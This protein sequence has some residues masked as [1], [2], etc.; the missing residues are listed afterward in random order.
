[1]PA[2]YPCALVDKSNGEQRSQRQTNE[3][4]LLVATAR[5]ATWGKGVSAMRA[6]T[7]AAVHAHAPLPT[8]CMRNRMDAQTA[9]QVSTNHM[10]VA[11]AI[12]A[13]TRSFHRLASMRT[14]LRTTAR[15]K[16]G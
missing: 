12:F 2:T 13:T 11:P 3:G 9:R 8:H 1:M 5:A 6:A 4:N 10:N 15:G 16:S 14:S 7:R